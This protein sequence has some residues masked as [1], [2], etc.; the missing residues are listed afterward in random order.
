[1]GFK[2]CI[3]GCKTGYQSNSNSPKYALFKFPTEAHLRKKWLT[4]IP[5]KDWSVS[6]SHRVCAK[7]FHETD[8]KTTSS[9]S[10]TQRRMSRETQ[11]LKRLRLNPEA[12]PKIFPGLPE[13]LSVPSTIE[14]SSAASSSKR[15]E[16]EL[17]RQEKLNDQFL[18]QDVL[19]NFD[20]LK[21]KVSEVILPSGYI[22]SVETDKIS[23]HCIEQDNDSSSAPKLGASVIIFA[24]LCFA[25]YVSSV[26]VPSKVFKHLI[27]NERIET[28]SGLNNVL[29]HCKSLSDKSLPLKNCIIE[30]VICYLKGFL[31][32][33]KQD[34]SDC[35]ASLI[36]FIVE[37]LQLFLLP[38][39]RRR[40]STK[41]ITMAFLW[42]LSSTSLYKK[43]RDLLILPSMSSLQTYS[44]GLTVKSGNLDVHYLKQRIEKL[45]DQ[46]RIV[47][48]LVDEVYTACRIEYSSGA[49]IGLTEDG[50][51]AKTVLTFMVQSTCC[52]YRDVVCLV[53]VNKLDTALLRLWF[54]KVM[55]ALNDL[56][57]V[58][59]VSV[60][61][62]I[63]N[64]YVQL[65]N[66]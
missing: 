15:A 27:T 55:L 43:L 53:P 4:A 30:K 65:D 63:C 25:A 60:D 42:Q 13:Y 21:S 17:M 40:Y 10:R 37:Q 41:T 66:L 14:R 11:S 29:A 12:I 2:C 36:D 50:T 48:L 34:N 38:K 52:K 44:S 45:S 28:L 62:H 57:F 35:N 61:N 1:M 59:A 49:F 7:H 6:D 64:R 26:Q 32:L 47:A 22:S 8:F 9:D 23:F 51:P 5:R 20:D 31:S 39:E 46:E 19:S 24:S 58:V 18:S 56:L 33:A 16:N 54:D 3:P